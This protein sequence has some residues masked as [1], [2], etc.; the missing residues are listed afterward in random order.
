MKGYLITGTGT[1]IGKSFFS[2]FLTENLLKRGRTVR[3]VKPVATGYPEDD[4]A[5]FVVA[6]TGLAR[7]DA[8]TLYTA[9]EPASPCFVFDPF[10]FEECVSRIQAMPDDRDVLLVET[11]GGIGVPLATRRYNYHFGLSLG[12]AVLLVVPNRLGCLSDSIVYGHFIL[13]H[14]MDFAGIVLNDHFAESPRHA[15][16]NA[17]EL[18]SEFPGKVVARYDVTGLTFT[19]VPGLDGEA[20]EG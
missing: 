17:A 13:R 10:P 1:G 15:D 18:E 8:V 20:G 9:A 5:A 14:K 4:D 7:E 6:R 3:Y 2:A 12:L 19:A 16:R 11:A